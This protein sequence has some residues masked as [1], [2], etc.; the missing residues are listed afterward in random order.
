[1]IYLQGLQGYRQKEEQEFE[2]NLKNNDTE[3]G[4]NIPSGL[5]DKITL[6]DM[7]E[8]FIDNAKQINLP[9]FVVQIDEITA[10]DTQ[11]VKLAKE[12]LLE[13]FQ[14]SKQNR[15]IPFSGI[16]SDLYKVYIVEEGK[17]EYS[18]EFKK[19]EKKHIAPLLDYILSVPKKEQVKQLSGRMTKLLGNMYPIPEQEINKY[20]NLILQDFTSEQMVDFVNHELTYKDKIKAWIKDLTTEHGETIFY[21]WYDTDKIQI[22]PAYTLPEQI[23]PVGTDT[24]IRKSLYGKEGKMNNFEAKAINDIANVKSVIFWTKNI[25]RKGFYINGFV[26][27]YPDFIVLTQKGNIL[28]V[29]TKGDDRDNS[30]SKRKLKLGK[31]WANMAGQQY[32]YFMI[33]ENSKIEGAY[34]LTDFVEMLEEM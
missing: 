5:M 16:T 15:E 2:E 13:G 34:S 19:V 20:L 27:H 7:K 17:G 9:Q 3:T 23:A 25:E 11:T 26:N 6:I 10:F 12:N 22:Q 30:D 24:G 28:I 21:E 29:E 1:M 31:S 4:Y 32:K 8:I 14:L 18:P 33:F